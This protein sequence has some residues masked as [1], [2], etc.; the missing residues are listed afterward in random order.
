MIVPLDLDLTTF[1][2]GVNLLVQ[3]QAILCGKP[4]YDYYNINKYCAYWRY[5]R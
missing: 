1:F 4:I 2:L 5:T 3:I